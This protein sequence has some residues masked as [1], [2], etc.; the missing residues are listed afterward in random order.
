V[1]I[2]EIFLRS[3][4]H[5]GRRSSRDRGSNGAEI[6]LV[7]LAI[8]LAILAPVVARILYFSCSRRREYL[9]DASA[10]RFT[11][12]PEG[13]AS[14]PEKISAQFQANTEVNKAPAPM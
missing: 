2:A 9:A 6:A 11:R 12:Y 7:V 3:G 4:F 13:L 14:A 10:A 5:R 8:V 1:L